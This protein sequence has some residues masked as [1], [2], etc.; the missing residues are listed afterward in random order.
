MDSITDLI[1]WQNVVAILVVY[2]ASVVFYRLFL[3]PLARF[4]G[5]KLAAITLWY[6]GFYDVIRNG[7]Y[8]FKIAE[9]HKKYGPIIRISPHELHV[10]DPSFFE[11][12]Y[13]QEGR[14]D[15]HAWAVDA[16]SGDGAFILT[17][18]HDLHKARRQPMNSFFSKA[19]VASKQ[20]IIQQQ[21]SKLCT[22]L[23]A[24]VDSK[25]A[26]NLGAAISAF[27]ADAS[28]SFIIAKSY[29][30]LDCEDFDI[31][32]MNAFQAN[33]SVWRITKHVRWYG[34]LMKSI[35][36][37]WVMKVVDDDMKAFFG[38]FKQNIQDTKD[39][40]ARASSS[41]SDDKGPRTIVNE[42]VESNLPAKEKAFERVQQ[43]V[44][45]VTGAGFETTA[46]AF[47]MIIYH[48]YS[49]KDILSR[50][51]AELAPAVR[52]SAKPLE[53]RTLEQLSYMTSII[54][55]GL[56]LSPAIASRTARIAPDRDLF[57]SDRSGSVKWRIPAGTPVGMTTL[58]MH[59][60]PTLYPEPMTF[61]PDRWMDLEFRKATSKTYAPF[62]RGTRSCIG[63]HFAWAKI[64]LALAEL[65]QRFDFQFEGISAEDF[66]CISDQFIIG[67]K[68]KGNVNAFVSKY[69]G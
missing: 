14:W 27:M 40:L 57:Y 62:S 32:I 55:E 22:R 38:Y 56:R 9:L 1:S 58:L 23:S 31:G 35:P 12:V 2:S 60:D 25:K 24:V 16:F 59:T 33:G 39:M 26:I 41:D 7:Q 46:G 6:E 49:N 29:D 47:K 67:T 20:H 34:P 8:T 54:M 43:D 13:C 21:V 10:I 64:Y 51:R 19:K 30:H 61:N 52:Q 42:I 3:H 63:M 68:A 44:A 45:T 5:P 66:E 15:K 53:L 48:V 36:I 18:N 28:T 50:L 65:V 37:D 4:P 17:S 69:S 11:K